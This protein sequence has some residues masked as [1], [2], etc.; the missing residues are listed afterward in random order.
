MTIFRRLAIF[1]VICVETPSAERDDKPLIL[2][3][4]LDAGRP[5]LSRQQARRIMAYTK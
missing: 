2:I 1:I 5:L 3:V 4:W